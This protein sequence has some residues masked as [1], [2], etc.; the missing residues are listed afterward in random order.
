VIDELAYIRDRLKAGQSSDELLMHLAALEADAYARGDPRS[1]EIAAARH[2]ALLDP[3]RAAAFLTRAFELE[4]P[5]SPETMPRSLPAGSPDRPDSP[6]TRRNPG[7]T[8]ADG[9]HGAVRTEAGQPAALALEPDILAQ[10]VT[11]L[12]LAGVAGEERT[13]QITFL[14]LTSRLLPWGR[15]GE[16][17]VS[18][19]TKGATSTGKSH[20]TR[21]TLRF[22]P[23]SA[24]VDLSSMSKKYL[25][26]AEESFAHKFI[27]IAEWATIKNDPELVAM[28]RVLLSE[29]RITHGTVEGE[30][31]KKGRM[32]EKS[33][34]TGLLMTTTEAILEPELETRCLSTTTDDSPEQTQRV[35]E[36]IARLED[37]AVEPD[38][39]RWHE[40]Q[41]WLA[42]HGETR[43]V[44][45]FVGALAA[46]MRNDSTRLRRDFVALLSLIRSHAILYRAQREVD[47]AGRIVA[48]ISDYA[49]VRELVGEIIAQGVDA[50]VSTALRDTVEAVQALEGMPKLAVTPSAVI[51]RLEV[52]RSAGYDRIKRALASGYLINETPHGHRGMR[53]VTGTPLPG[54]G[55]YLPE[56]HDIVRQMSETSTGHPT[57]APSELSHD[58]SGRPGRPGL[59]DHAAA[60]GVVDDLEP[61]ACAAA[62]EDSLPSATSP[63]P[64]GTVI[65]VCTRCGAGVGDEDPTIGAWDGSRWRFT[66]HALRGWQELS[67]AASLRCRSCAVGAKYNLIPLADPDAIRS[68]KRPARS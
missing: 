32:I 34:P 4:A 23:A 47:A 42:T 35:F 55:P 2:E 67:G 33:G 8:D 65:G 10:F 22:F 56:A 17:L 38:F 14:A 21:T 1:G 28:L 50:A 61:G 16:R 30:G 24:Y 7:P 52:G 18:V 29:G 15:P 3:R 19:V 40:F 60:L 31:R 54:D 37:S 5:A 44:I 27:Y 62:P 25:F 58:A 48:T 9:V 59:G 12:K 43:V 57:T 20:A 45:P 39:A 26:Y 49:A 36:A 51:S 66:G 6:T 63:T 13:A 64:F 46:K 53:L 41:R 68:S 11:D